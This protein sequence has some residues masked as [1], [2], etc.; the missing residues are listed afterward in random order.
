MPLATGLTYVGIGKETVKGTGVPATFFLPV[1]TDNPFDNQPFLDDKSW[2]GSMNELYNT[3][4]NVEHSEYDLGGPVFADAV[5][6]PLCGI[7]GDVTVSTGRTVTD[8]VT[9]NSSTTV[10]SATAAFT[11]ADI[12]RTITGTNI[13]ALATIVTVGSATSVTISAA[14]TGSGTGITLTIGTVGVQVHRAAVQNTVSTEGQPVSHTLTD[15]Y[16]LT[17]GTPARQYAGMQWTEVGF[18]FAADAMFEWTGKALGFVST[19]VAKPAQTFTSVLPFPTWQGVAT[20][21]GSLVHY[22]EA[23]EWTVKRVGT[24]LATVNGSQAPYKIWVGVVTLEGKLTF[25]A[26]DDTELNRY[27][28]NTEPSLDLTF[29]HGSGANAVG[30]TLHAGS[31]TYMNGKPNRGKDYIAY[32][33]DFKATAQVSDAGVSGGYSTGYAAVTNSLA[34]GTY[35]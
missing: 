31:A 2:R 21:G 27:L 7:Y 20:I 23:G 32:D 10:T 5:G 17:G 16:G 30:V 13:P 26:E 24:A 11:I 14:A 18:K 29:T 6:W 9:T 22:L 3:I 15:F 12:G 19:L 35:A 25:I 8:G 33:V 1:T 4:P 34:T 28:N